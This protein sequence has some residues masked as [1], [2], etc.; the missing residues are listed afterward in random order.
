[1]DGVF[2]LLLCKKVEK[3]REE[4]GGGERT[5]TT[6]HKHC[7][8]FLVATAGAVKA[9]EILKNEVGGGRRMYFLIKP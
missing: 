2:L 4:R 6:P 7:L 5:E 1:M 3:R 8:L 9:A